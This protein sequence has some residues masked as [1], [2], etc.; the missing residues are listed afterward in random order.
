MIGF[1]GLKSITMYQNKAFRNTACK[2]L[3]QYDHEIKCV[4]EKQ[5]L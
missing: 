3:R 4:T 2:V 1:F 5:E